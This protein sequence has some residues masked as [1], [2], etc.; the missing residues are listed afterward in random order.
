MGFAGVGLDLDEGIFWLIGCY[1]KAEARAG[2]GGDALG[3]PAR[4]VEDFDLSAADGFK[5]GEAAFDL[6]DDLLLGGV[7]GFGE[8]ECDVDAMARRD[9]GNSGAGRVGIGRNG[10]VV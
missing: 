2:F 6:G 1:S 3:S 9:A 10:D 7:A 4:F 8:G 5:G